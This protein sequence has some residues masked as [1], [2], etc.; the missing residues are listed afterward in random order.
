MAALAHGLG[1]ASTAEGVEDK[2]Q[3]ATITSEGC[4]EMQGYLLSRPLPARE[5]QNFLLSRRKD[6]EAKPDAAAA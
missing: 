2:E 1:I 4:T 6:R 5:I 3:L